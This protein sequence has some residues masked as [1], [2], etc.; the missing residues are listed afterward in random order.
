MAES[1]TNELRQRRSV[2]SESLAAMGRKRD[3]TY[4][5]NNDALALD[6]AGVT[7]HSPE[8]L[9]RLAQGQAEAEAAIR[10]AQCEIRELDAEIHRFVHRVLD[11]RPVD[12]RQHFLG[13]RL[14]GGQ[15]AGAEP[16]DREHGLADSETHRCVCALP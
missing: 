7:N 3:A 1:K 2:L 13:H 6:R 12:D 8:E 10:D 9:T 5:L 4:R 16:R 15:E 11:Q 14:G